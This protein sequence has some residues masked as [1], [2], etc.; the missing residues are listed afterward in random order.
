MMISRKRESGDVNGLF[1]REEQVAK[2][3]TSQNLLHHRTAP[4]M[5][6]YQGDIERGKNVAYL[7]FFALCMLALLKVL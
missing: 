1:I 3:L 5:R 2:S 4:M 7:F 6:I